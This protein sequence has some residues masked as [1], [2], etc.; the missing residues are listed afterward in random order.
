[1]SER[2]TLETFGRRRKPDYVR[3]F[4]EG[5]HGVTRIRVQWKQGALLKTESFPDTRKG[6]A[7]AKAFAEGVHER[8]QTRAPEAIAPI[9]L[10]GLFDKHVAA[11]DTVW[12]A[13]TLRLLTW[14]WGKLELAIGRRTAAHTISRETLDDLKRALLKNHSPNQVRLA[15]KAV[16]SVL[17]WA[18][19]RDL[20]PPTKATSY[21][22]EFSKD[23]ERSGPVMAEY[24][25]NERERVLAQLDPRD[26][27]NWRTFVYTTLL[28]Y[29]GPRQRAARYLEWDDVDLVDGTLTWRPETDKTGAGRVQPLPRPVLEAL[30]VAYGWRLAFG[31]T[32]RFVFFRP[33]AG[34]RDPNPNFRSPGRAARRAKAHPDIPWS[35]AAFNGALRRAEKAAGIVH[36]DYRAA[37]GFRRGIAGDVHA[38]TGSSKK[39]AEWIG[40]KSTR[41][42][43][44]HYILRRDD[45]LRATADLVSTG[46]ETQRATN[47][48][49]PEESK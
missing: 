2:K 24:S 46:N 49:D 14:R 31:Y 38:K 16:T 7:E 42:V 13:S 48:G 32:G 29:C 35:Y 37:H 22:V 41:I 23:I 30:W 20:I 47:D 44:K 40:D 18:V 27:R 28:A 25:G 45:E 1:M 17:R 34:S 3:I 36:V 11:K 5:V 21:A 39:A 33:G 4:R 43:E 26:S 12:R 10:R 6:I 15:I 9:S 19:D 8:L